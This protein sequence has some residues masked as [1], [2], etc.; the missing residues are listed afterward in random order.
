[1]NGFSL[2]W[3]SPDWETKAVYAAA[4]V[5][6]KARH[7][8]SESHNF[9]FTAGGFDLDDFLGWDREFALLA[10]ASFLFPLMVPS[11]APL[12]RRAFRDDPIGEPVNQSDNA[13][14]GLRSFKGADA[15]VIKLARRKN[16]EGGAFSS[17]LS[18]LGNIHPVRHALLTGFGRG[19]GCEFGFALFPSYAK[20]NSDRHLKF[21]LRKMDMGMPVVTRLR[22]F[23]EGLLRNFYN[24]DRRLP[25]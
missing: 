21:V 2:V 15:L 25:W 10:F 4:D 7:R 20:N 1:M 13:L 6:R 9:R 5:L 23:E 14:V 16:L 19:L 24:A 3:A 18:F 17:A 12:R 8:A 22:L 11:E